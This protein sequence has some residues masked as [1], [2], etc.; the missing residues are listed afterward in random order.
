MSRLVRNCMFALLLVLPALAAAAGP[1]SAG[2]I[3]FWMASD[4]PDPVRVEF[5]ASKQRYW[6]GNGLSYEIDDWEN[7]KYTL[8]CSTGEK[9]CYGA[10]V[11][12]GTT[13]WGL[14]YRRDRTCDDCCYTCGNGNATRL[15]TLQP[16]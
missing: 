15:I 3:T 14:G 6:P 2:S 10:W 11:S 16:Y 13:R 12:N 1:A 4:Y 7:H 8:N 9:V 5:S